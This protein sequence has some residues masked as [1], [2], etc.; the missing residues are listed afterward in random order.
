[1]KFGGGHVELPEVLGLPRGERVG[2][3]G[4][5]VGEGHE[6]EHLEQ[7][8]AADFFGEAAHVFEV[9][10]V[11]AHGVRHFQ[12]QADELENGLALFG[13]EVEAGEKAVGQLDALLRV[14]AGAAAFAGVVQQ[15]GEEE[16]VE[17]VDFGEQ[18]RQALL[19][20]VRGRAQGV[21]I[22]DD[23]EGV[24]VDGVAVVAVA[25][26]E[27][28]DAVELGDEHLENAERVHGAQRVRGVGAEQDFAQRVPEIGPFGDVR[29]RGRA[30]RR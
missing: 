4:L 22:V 12:M 28:V 7:L 6:R 29:W 26:D 30:A 19:V 21:D 5:D 9:E 23:E 24:L 11:A 10:D 27:R 15:Q 17:A 13:V 3:D 8:R 25:D 18:L 2:V 1:M 14:L 16:E 20:L